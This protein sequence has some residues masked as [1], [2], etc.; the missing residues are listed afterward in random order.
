MNKRTEDIIDTI[1]DVLIFLL[2]NI[3]L[4]NNANAFFKEGKIYVA[5]ILLIWVGF[6]IGFKVAQ[7]LMARRIKNENKNS[8][9]NI[10]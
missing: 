1:L 6:C 10:N 2:I 7:L 3:A 9:R 5:F 4:I 8:K